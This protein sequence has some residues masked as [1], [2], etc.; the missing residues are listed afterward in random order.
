MLQL[1][2]RI[3]KG[4]HVVGSALFDPKEEHQQRF[5]LYFKF[6]SVIRDMISRRSE[7]TTVNTHPLMEA[8][9]GIQKEFDGRHQRTYCFV[10]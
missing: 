10:V 1:I 9:I 6:A 8:L 5:P 3:A 2:A 4:N 7:R